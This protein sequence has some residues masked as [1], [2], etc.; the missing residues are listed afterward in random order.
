VLFSH[1]HQGK[2]PQATWHI[3]KHCHIEDKSLQYK[4]HDTTSKNM[5]TSERRKPPTATSVSMSNETLLTQLSASP[6]QYGKRTSTSSPSCTPLSHCQT[7]LSRS[8]CNQRPAC[9]PHSCVV[10]IIGIRSMMWSVVMKVL[11]QPVLAFLH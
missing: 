4:L 2:P 5:A 1:H 8:W 7:L 10:M 11:S 6:L 3:K 9:S